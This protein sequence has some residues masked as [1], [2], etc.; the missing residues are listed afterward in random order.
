MLAVNEHLQDLMSFV[1]SPC[2]GTSILAFSFPSYPLIPS[3]ADPDFPVQIFFLAHA[4]RGFNIPPR[5]ESAHI[6]I[7]I[8][9]LPAATTHPLPICL[10]TP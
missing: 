9:L 10:L 6:L 8:Y 4:A 1:V 5:H 3:L 7:P 2:C